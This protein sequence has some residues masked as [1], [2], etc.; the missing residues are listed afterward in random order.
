M[1]GPLTPLLTVLFLI[2]T[3][4]RN[5]ESLKEIVL[6]LWVSTPRNPTYLT[7]PVLI[8]TP[9]RNRK[10]FK[11]IVLGLRMSP[12]GRSEDMLST[13]LVEPEGDKDSRP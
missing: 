11:E 9:G 13:V 7:T 1:C 5:R 8:E 6:R 4:R 3:P 12:P 2:K 10:G